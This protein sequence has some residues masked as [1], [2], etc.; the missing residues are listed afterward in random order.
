MKRLSIILLVAIVCISSFAINEEKKQ[1][2]KVDQLRFSQS[3]LTTAG[4]SGLSASGKSFRANQTGL[5][6]SR[7]AR[8]KSTWMRK[9]QA[10]SK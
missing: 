9:G 2:K 7:E 3:L 5:P 10:A 8:L 4:A 1:R 6:T